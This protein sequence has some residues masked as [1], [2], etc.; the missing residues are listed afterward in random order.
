MAIVRCRLELVP[1]RYDARGRRPSD[2]G[3]ADMKAESKIDGVQIGVTRASYAVT[4]PGYGVTCAC[5]AVKKGP[6]TA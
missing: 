3:E 1:L 2:A 4:R 6:V 5:Y